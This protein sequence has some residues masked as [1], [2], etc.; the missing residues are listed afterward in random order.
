MRFIANSS[1]LYKKLSLL[2]GLI[3][4]NPLQKILTYLHFEL[5]D[6]KLRITASD[7]DT[8][9]SV[10]M[11]A[12]EVQEAGEICIPAK[13]LIDYLRNLSDQPLSFQISA[14]KSTVEI[15]SDSGKYR[16]TTAHPR[17]FPKQV[18]LEEAERFSLPT[19]FLVY[20]LRKTLFAISK[21]TLR[22]AMTGLFFEI[23]ADEFCL[24]S[25][26]SHRLIQVT[27]KGSNALADKGFIVP[28]KS[29]DLLLTLI[30][31]AEEDIEIQF[32]EREAVFQGP[33]FRL[34]TRLVDATFPPYRTVIPTDNPYTLVINRL[35]FLHALK[36]IS[37]F[38]NK[39]T[40]LMVM[41]IIGNSVRLMGQD[42][43]MAYE[44]METL[45]CQYNGQD[46]KLAFNA[47]LIVELLATLGTEEIKIEISSP[48]RACIF[49][50]SEF[51]VNTDLLMLLMPFKVGV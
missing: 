32:D 40:N 8:M 50:E 7:A 9:L 47:A 28:K 25:T 37:I 22:P 46:M 44:G 12:Q 23:Q 15:T 39:S 14:D 30:S 45:S 16:I 24:V 48:S 36:R 6:Q 42:L 26:D 29:A 17:E 31:Q 5:L 43:E 4:P 33:M 2:S 51:P 49:R 3:A 13:I 10:V 27:R 41:E 21:E 18:P 20:G 19:D 38:A 34:S 11:A 35:D 1:A